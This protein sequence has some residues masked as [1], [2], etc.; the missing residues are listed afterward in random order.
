MTQKLLLSYVSLITKIWNFILRTYDDIIFIKNTIFSFY[1]PSECFFYQRV[2]SIRY[3]SKQYAP[4][5]MSSWY[6]NKHNSYQ[7]AP[8]SVHIPPARRQIVLFYLWIGP[9]YRVHMLLG[10]E[11]LNG[12]FIWWGV[13][14]KFML[15]K[16]WLM[17]GLLR[18]CLC[19]IQRDHVKIGFISCVTT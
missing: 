4:W 2:G 3:G 12:S 17:L 13:L 1:R 19:M 5:H 14:I 10:F 8:R 16:N 15:G 11:R 7:L 6:K 9:L 18:N